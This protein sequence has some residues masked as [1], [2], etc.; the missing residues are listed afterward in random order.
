MSLIV[1]INS[2][3]ETLRV[4]SIGSV[5]AG[6][7]SDLVDELGFSHFLPWP[8][9]TIDASQADAALA[10]LAKL[11]EARESERGQW[12]WFRAELSALKAGESKLIRFA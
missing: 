2:D 6:D 10:E 5:R 8:A 4:Y 1:R 11:E 9:M 7:L 3:E 12:D